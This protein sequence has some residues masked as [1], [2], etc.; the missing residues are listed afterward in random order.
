MMRIISIDLER[1]ILHTDRGSCPIQMMLDY[2]GEETSIPELAEQ[3]I[4]HI[5]EAVWRCPQGQWLRIN[6]SL[7]KLP[8]LH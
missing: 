7:F 8:T 2:I 4:A 5:P 1:G 6:L 3:I